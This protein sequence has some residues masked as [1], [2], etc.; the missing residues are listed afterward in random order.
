[1]KIGM[2]GGMTGHGRGTYHVAHNTV[3][4]TLQTLRCLEKIKPQAKDPNI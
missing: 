3:H 2:E 1:M 4:H